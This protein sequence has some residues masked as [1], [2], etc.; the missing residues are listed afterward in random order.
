LTLREELVPILHDLVS[1]ADEIEVVA[2]QEFGHHVSPVGETHPAIILAPSVNIFVGVGPEEITEKTCVGNVGGPHYATN[3]LHRLK[4]GTETA[5]A[6][7]NLLVDDGCN[8]ETV[9]AVGER[10]PELDVVPPL[11]FVVESVYPV[12]AG[13]LVVSAEQ[14]EILG[15]L[16]LVSE[17]E[18]DGLERLLTPVHVVPEEEV[19]GFRGE[20]A[21]LE[22]TKEVRELTVDV[23]ADFERRFEFQ[24]NWL[25]QK[26]FPGLEAEPSNFSLGHLDSFARPRTSNLEQSLNHSVDIDLTLGH[27]A[28]GFKVR[29]NWGSGTF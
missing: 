4:I 24:E 17:K 28:R 2:V 9:E 23:A 3:L 1:S 6:A 13:A 21:V 27:L 15:I 29:N 16:D 25:L 14:E 20:P 26:D 5:V 12:D 22:Q 18:A 11:A 8:G 19:V 7:E 10:L